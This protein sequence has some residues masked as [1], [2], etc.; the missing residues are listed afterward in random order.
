MNYTK[1]TSTFSTTQIGS[2][3]A[4]QPKS[5]NNTFTSLKIERPH[6][7]KHHIRQPQRFGTPTHTKHN[8]EPHAVFISILCICLGVQRTP[9]TTTNH[10]PFYFYI[11]YMF[12]GAK[13]TKHNHEPH[14]VFISILSICLGA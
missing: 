3:P 6:H 1:Q 9:N 12:G 7:T 5:H 13:H 2:R 8:H 4:N 11:I 10:N 14:A